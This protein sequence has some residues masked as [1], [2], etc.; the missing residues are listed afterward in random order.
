MS[1]YK[2]TI[3]PMGKMAASIRRLA[4]DAQVLIDQENANDPFVKRMMNLVK[5]F[6]KARRVL[7]YGGTALNNLL[8]VED[9]FYDP[10][11][12][13]PDYDFFSETP[14]EDAMKLADILHKEGVHAV[15]V[16]PGLHLGT[17]KV[18]AAYIG[19]ADITHLESE[20][21]ERLWKERI[22]K[23]DISYAPPNY[24]RMS[25]Y[26]ELSRPRGDVSRWNKI[27]SR[28]SAFNKHYPITCPA[29]PP[30]LKNIDEDIRNDIEEYMKDQHIVLLGTN[31]IS[32]T[33]S[34]PIDGL[35]IPEHVHRVVSHLARMIGGKV[36]AYTEY[37]DLLPP[38]YDVRKGKTLV[39][40]I[41]ETTA[42][43]SYHETKTGLYVASIPTLLQFSLAM[44]Y[45]DSHF[46]E[47]S[48]RQRLSCTA[49]MLIDMANGDKKRRFRV[50]TPITCIG[51]QQSAVD[52]RE[53]KA[54]LYASL[55]KKR[56]TPE[57]LEYFFSYRPDETNPT[58]KR[59]LKKNLPSA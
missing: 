15:E 24:L 34:L 51:T 31:A 1:N 49:Q 48:S 46:L 27:Y 7:C 21:F 57:F 14:Q 29:P 55:K 18:F 8:P 50:L 20:V 39:F 3:L 47:A 13:I 59:I 40:R 9:Q 11:Q 54:E 41:F 6:L 5:S 19:V 22:E 42:C 58:Q 44:M 30:V 33:W 25:L 26:L 43:H 12:D 56:S 16:K 38:H 53:E 32:D 4:N 10:K 37:L 35:C 17:F 28:L 23:E 52:M 45:S 36:S 2:K